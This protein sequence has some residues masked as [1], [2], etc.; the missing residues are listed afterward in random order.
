[1]ANLFTRFV[2][3]VCDLLLPVKHDIFFGNEKSKI[4]LCTLSSMDMLQQVSKSDLMNNVALAARLF[5]ENNGIEKLLKYVLEHQNIKYIVLCGKDT[6]GHLPG[7]ALLALCKN[8]IDTNSRIIGALGK[9][10][11]LENVSKS[12]VDR[13]R[14]HVHI[15]DLI[16]TT[17]ISE[18]SSKVTSLVSQ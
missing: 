16:G 14:E 8:G 1:M 4:T 7:Q 9:D 12:A 5:S 13:F 10:P 2:G 15:I 11:V 17:D 3:K 6:K 18:I